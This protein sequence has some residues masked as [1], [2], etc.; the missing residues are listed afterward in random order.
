MKMGK[1]IAALLCLLSMVLGLVACGAGTESQILGAWV[2]AEDDRYYIEFYRNGEMKS[3][4]RDRNLSEEGRW[5]LVDDDSL[6]I[7][8]DDETITAKIVSISSDKL[9]LDNSGHRLELVREK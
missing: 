7:T 4:R 2:Q 3:G 5:E 9:I 8:A 1:R 6:M